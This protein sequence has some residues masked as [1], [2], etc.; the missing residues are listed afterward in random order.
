MKT[1]KLFENILWNPSNN[2]ILKSETPQLDKY[3][4]TLKKPFRG[5]V[6]PKYLRDT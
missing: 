3:E 6:S 5:G 2:N 1:V 4:Y